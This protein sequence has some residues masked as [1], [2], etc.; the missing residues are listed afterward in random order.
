MEDV[1]GIVLERHVFFTVAK[2]DYEDPDV[3]PARYANPLQLY[4]VTPERPFLVVSHV[5]TPGRERFF[6]MDVVPDRL[7]F[8][9]IEVVT[10]AGT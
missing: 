5:F 3:E 8:D 10:D 7:S 9:L 6:D 1:H 4:R 2:A